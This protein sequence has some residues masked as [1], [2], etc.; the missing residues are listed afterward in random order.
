M[1][2]RER[3]KSH[4]IKT[5]KL[6]SLSCCLSR[7]V[8]AFV[9]CAHQV[10][11]EVL[12]LLCIPVVDPDKE[13]KNW[14]RP[15][16]CLQL[17]TA[18]LVCLLTFRSGQCKY[19]TFLIKKKKSRKLYHRQPKKVF[20]SSVQCSDAEYMIQGQFPLWLLILLLGLFL[21][22]IVFCTTTNNCPPR[23]HPV[24]LGDH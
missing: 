13:D 16:N 12:L 18:P 14:R 24:G 6:K 8:V 3:D 5:A 11:T 21:S 17:I 9:S 4:S 20:V 1:C 22:A 2:V 15:L 23:Y 19:I 10:P 7:N